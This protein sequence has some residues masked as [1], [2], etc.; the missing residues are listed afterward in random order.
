MSPS[1]L[2][3]GWEKAYADLS[4]QVC[5]DVDGGWLLLLLY[6]RAGDGIKFFFKK[7]ESII[8]V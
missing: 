5:A 4:G 7:K 1:V 6:W 3:I 2:R 8:L